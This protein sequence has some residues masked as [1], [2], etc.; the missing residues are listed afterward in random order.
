MISKIDPRGDLCDQIVDFPLPGGLAEA[1]PE[2]TFFRASIFGCILVAFRHHFGQGFALRAP[3]WRLLVVFWS[4]KVP[5]CTKTPRVQRATLPLDHSFVLFYMVLLEPTFFRASIF[6]CFL[7]PFR[8]PFGQCWALLAP[9]WPLLAPCWA[10]LA[11]FWEHFG[12]SWL[13]FVDF[14]RILDDFS[15]GFQRFCTYFLDT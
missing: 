14:G 2:P 8:R 3:S 11:P 12:R 15:E 1:A 7:V 13:I 6:R 4:P 5:C 10:L 9:F